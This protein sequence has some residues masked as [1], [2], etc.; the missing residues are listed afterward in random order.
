M[1]VFQGKVGF[2]QRVLPHYRKP[3][4]ETL[5]EQCLGRLSIFTGQPRLDEMIK[6][7]EEL[8]KAQLS[9]GRNLHILKGSL[10][11][12]IQLRLMD[13]LKS[14]DP[15]VL[16]VEANPRYL[17][18]PGGVRWMH[19]KG[20]PVI[21][22]GL[23]APPIS[24]F[25]GRIRTSRRKD[26]LSQFDALITYSSSGAAEYADLGFPKDQIFVAPNAVTPPPPHPIPDRPIPVE[27]HPVR[28]LFVGR[29]QERKNLD[30]LIIA[31]SHLP[32]DLQ[33]ELVIVGDGPDHLRLVKM[34]EEVYP[35]TI[36]T[37]ALYENDLAEQFRM[38][39]LFVLPG[40]G[41]LAVQQAMSYALPVI[42]AQADGTQEDLISKDNGWQVPAD[43]LP[44]LESTLREALENKPKLREMGKESY[45]IVA[46]EINLEKMV[47][48]FCEVINRSLS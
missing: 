7:V 4:F 5:G 15:D 28:I 18:T 33:P 9:K 41:G 36:F 37:S 35:K 24:G 13:W 14:W 39:D 32:E 25:F 42:A 26:F 38:A 20:R 19:D 12:C 22:W 27:D 47:E 6:P 29:L 10:Y 23:G 16:I 17:S 21:G 40:T 31:C 44:A 34:A 48:V 1:N 3:F 46:E 2:I 8:E 11:F 43:D 30:N 45:R